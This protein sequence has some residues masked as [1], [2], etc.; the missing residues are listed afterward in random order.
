MSERID[1]AF[2]QWATIELNSNCSVSDS[3]VPSYV[4]TETLDPE[5]TRIKTTF[6]NLWNPIAG[7]LGQPSNW[8]A[9]QV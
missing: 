3:A 1:K 6:V 9:D 7:Q 8:S 5:S 4:A 2:A